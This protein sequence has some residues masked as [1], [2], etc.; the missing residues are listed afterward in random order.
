MNIYLL[1]AGSL[2]AIAALLHLGCIYF[3]ASW[4]RFF[5]AGEKMALMAEQGSYQPTLITLG[6]FSVLALWSAYAF[7]AAGLIAHLPFTRLVLPLITLVYLVRG[8]A[9][10]TLM[11]NPMGRSPEF[12]LWSSAICLTL[13]IFHVIG[14]TTQWAK[15]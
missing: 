2:S 10:F 8:L 3:G 7:S 9:G 5:G 13:G 6:I 14:L 12:W 15:L 4:Y 11:N 1:I